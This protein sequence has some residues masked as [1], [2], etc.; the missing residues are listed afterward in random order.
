MKLAVHPNGSLEVAFT[1]ENH[2][3]INLGQSVVI[4]DGNGV[5]LAVFEDELDGLINALKAMRDVILPLNKV[6]A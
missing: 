5:A 6:M 4:R 1:V 2:P 3:A